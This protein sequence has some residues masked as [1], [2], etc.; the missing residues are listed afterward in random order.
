MHPDT[1]RLLSRFI[2]CDNKPGK[3]R[4]LEIM[5]ASEITLLSGLASR[6]R[7]VARAEP[8]TAIRHR[9]TN[10]YEKV[11]EFLNGAALEANGLEAETWELFSVD[12]SCASDTF[13]RKVTTT[14][15][16]EWEAAFG[17]YMCRGTRQCLCLHRRTVSLDSSL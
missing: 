6:M 7:R 16:E 13:A 14:F 1:P 9:E 3:R 2:T 17:L 11:A 5:P 15:L 8:C 4:G 10:G 12:F